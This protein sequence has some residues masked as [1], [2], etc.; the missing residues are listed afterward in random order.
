MKFF[1][2]AG[3]YGKRAQPLSLVKPKPIFPLHGTPL[4][5]LLLSGLKTAGFT[6]G[7][8][9]LHY[10]PEA[11]RQVTGSEPGLSITYLYEKKLSG[12]KILVQSLPHMKEGEDFLFIMNGDVF[13]E[14]SRIPVERMFREVRENRCDGVL[15]LRKNTDPAYKSVITGN[16]FFKYTEIN[17]GGESLMYTGVAIFRKKI[18]EKIDHIRF[19]NTLETHDFTIKTFVYDGTWMDI[20]D[21]RL[22]FEANAG[23]KH[24]LNIDS[25][26]NSLSEHVTISPGSRVSNCIA[27]ENT[28][29]TGRSTLSNCIVTGNVTLRD[30]DYSD[31]IIYSDGEKSIVTDLQK[32]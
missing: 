11:I 3:G 21:P 5:T 4:I 7:F 25:R 12:S 29:I 27:W 30:V 23:Y 10:K 28:A 15:L 26:E 13:L 8:I 1:I 19:F 6:E 14:F 20:G 18:V 2:L 9:N 17:K 32:I 31:K 22:Y 16:G 24:R